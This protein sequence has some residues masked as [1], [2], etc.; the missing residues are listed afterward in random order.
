MHLAPHP[1]L[2][3]QS[4]LFDYRTGTHISSLDAMSTWDWNM[5]SLYDLLQKGIEKHRDDPCF[6]KRRTLDEPVQWLTYAEVDE[7]VRKVGSAFTQFCA[8]KGDGLIAVGIYCPNSPEWMMTA[9]ACHAYGFV[10]LPLYDTLGSEGLRHICQQVEP[11]F[12]IC[13]KTSSANNIFDWA[14]PALKYVIVTEPDAEFEALRQKQ[15]KLILWNE[16]ITIGSKCM[17]K[18][19]KPSKDDL[20][21]ICYTSGSEGLPKGVLFSY[22][23]FMNLSMCVTQI[24]ERFTHF[25]TYFKHMSYLPLAHVLEHFN[26]SA[27]LYKGA[28]I[29]F[30]TGDM[31]GF[32]DDLQTYTPH[33]LPTVPRILMRIYSMT[34]QKLGKHGIGRWLLQQ[35]INQ[36]LREQRRGLYMRKGIV[37]YLIF[38]PIRRK[39][40][41]N[42]ELICCAGAPL[43]SDVLDFTRAV[44]SCPVFEVYG[45]TE[46]GGVVSC[47]L[48]GETIPGH[49]GALC[50]TFYVKLVDVPDMD[51]VVS[52]DNM[53]EVCVKGD[54]CS[55][56]FYKD[57][58]KTRAVIDADGFVHMGDIGVW[59]EQGALKIVDRCKNIFKLAQGEYICPGKIEEIYSSSPLVANV[60][61]DGNSFHTFPVAVIEPNLDNLRA[62]M[63]VYSNK[64][65]HEGNSARPPNLLRFMSDAD[66]CENQ[67]AKQI[68]L[69]ELMRIGKKN[70]LKGFE[71]VKAVHLTPDRFTIEN[72]L[73][74]P[75]M[76]LSRPVARRRFAEVVKRL[77]KEVE[78]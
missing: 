47:T 69:Q 44:F 41:S 50:P 20:A 78:L 43:S 22:K 1:L 31:S 74:T 48:P 17:M 26:M 13:D 15:P 38:R 27:C 10:S 21:M 2:D 61:V 67:A 63:H 9:L 25:P 5:V 18:P 29:G 11:T 6:G 73:L 33:Y 7:R 72:S 32:I 37:D 59:T 51:I 30:R 42:I 65:N 39:F 66:L 28:Q 24:L 70:G 40:G 56:G 12:V 49:S 58:A 62:R 14:T 64:C 77:Y 57:E 46:G 36:K 23:T 52:R 19:V 4:I 34:M 45:S 3:R 16:L 54:S 35:A 68:V 8:D 75:T 76:K 55:T 71:H 60:Y 53:G